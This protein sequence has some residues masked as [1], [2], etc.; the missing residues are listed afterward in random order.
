MPRVFLCFI[1][2]AKKRK[3]EKKGQSSGLEQKLEFCLAL[4]G[5]SLPTT[6]SPAILRLF[7]VP[8]E[9]SRNQNL[10]RQRQEGH[11]KKREAVP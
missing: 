11:K 4:G 5:G 2:K 3:T 7:F 6:A 1:V 9:R 8:P 10:Y